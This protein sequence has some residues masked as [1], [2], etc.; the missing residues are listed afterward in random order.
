MQLLSASTIGAFAAA[1]VFFSLFAVFAALWAGARSARDK[2]AKEAA[3]SGD[4]LATTPEGLFVWDAGSGREICSR[5]LAALLGLA[6]GVE[7]TY[8]NLRGAFE[9]DASMVF[10]QAVGSLRR[11]GAAFDIFIRH[12]DRPLH[13]VGRRAFRDGETH[14][15]DVLW[16]RDMDGVSRALDSTG[17]ASAEALSAAYDSFQ[18]LL[19]ALPIPIWLRDSE[20]NV[21]FANRACNFVAYAEQAAYVADKAR[22][23]NEPLSELINVSIGDGAQAE[24]QPFQI[25]EVPI[26][27][28]V[29]TAGFAVKSNSPAAVKSNSPTVM[30]SNSP[31]AMSGKGSIPG[32]E[33]HIL[34]EISSAVAIFNADKRLIFANTAYAQM[35]RLDFSY[36]TGGPPLSELLDR[37]R[38]Q[39]RLPEVADFR[40]FKASILAR[41]DSMQDEHYDLHMPDGTSLRETVTP[42]GAGGMAFIYEDVTDRLNLERDVATAGAVQREALGNLHE[43][44]AVFGGNGRL[45]LTNPALHRIWGLSSGKIG[46]STHIREFIDHMRPFI[47]K[48]QDWDAYRE[49][50]A[51]RLMSRRGQAGRLMRNDGSALDYT[52]VPLPDGGVLLSYLDVSDSAKVEA[53]LRERAQA[54]DEAG[55]LKSSFIAN[56]SYEIR[57]PMNT[58]MG[59]SQTLN[60]E[61]FGPL[62]KRQKEYAQGIVEAS[63]GLM[64]VIGN[65][66]DLA[67]IE[68]GALSLELDT[69]DLHSTLVSVL[70]LIR[71]R[72]RRGAVRLEFDCPTDIGW[73]V[74][75]E[76]RLRQVLFNLLSNAVRFTP[77]R[78]TIL[79]AAAHKGQEV[80]IKIADT[81]V[82]IPQADL[83]R[84]FGAFEKTPSPA[85]GQA[86][87]GLGLAI[88]KQFVKM[89]GGVVDIRS[90]S[91]RGATVR[92][93]LPLSGPADGQDTYPESSTEEA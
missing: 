68:A 84:V 18:N 31:T 10:D 90:G 76:I 67:S 4:I 64:D 66:L 77:P 75:D 57:T 59:F 92:L 19:N 23:A 93:R 26:K 30:K 27:G 58:I 55:R 1:I 50:M 62:N 83:D 72:A 78:G 79:L 65:I 17:G 9:G 22:K 3:K 49:E 37:C 46:A 14:V 71:E 52:N 73:I 16:V 2:L 40:A 13:M 35:M 7:A 87:A 25:T 33:G 81:G 29:G 89:H 61:Y 36:L 51:G 69:V 63:Q 70:G 56:V 88:V 42:H 54:L 80:E 28:W 34:E 21:A 11:S 43:G 39:R 47:S 38:E 85:G 20:L 5:R 48:I 74:A 32:P 86:G 44:V 53:A 60:E 12:K 82:G 45:R 6:D 8:Y 91:G 15:A 41:F 24:T